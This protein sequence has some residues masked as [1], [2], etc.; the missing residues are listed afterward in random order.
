[1]DKK[2]RKRILILIIFIAILCGLYFKVHH[3]GN[4]DELVLYGNVE[5]RQVDLGFRVE[6]K[7]QKM[8]FEEGDYV[9]K[10]DLLAALDNVNYKATYERSLAEIEMSKATSANAAIKYARN[11][12]LCADGTVSKQDCDNLKN[13]KDSSKASL[14]AAIESSKIAKKNLADSTIKAPDDG[15]IMTR[16]QEPGAALAADQPIYTMAKIQPVWIRTYIPETDLGNIRY[17]MK[18]N[19]YTDSIDPKTGKHRQYTGWVGY[20]SPVAEFTPKTVETTNLRTD[21]V[22]RIRVYVYDIDE[23]LRQGMPTTIKFDLLNKETREEANKND[24]NR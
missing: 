13:L 18:A 19:V 23:Y 7:L 2:K 11:L 5:I 15:I 20:I 24:K 3:K 22:Y 17:G 14:D 12:P 8:Y 9:K 6:G 21:L 16:I 10:G 1:M 4:P